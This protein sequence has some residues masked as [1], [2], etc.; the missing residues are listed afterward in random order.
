MT[1]Y[2]VFRISKR[3]R[4]RHDFLEAPLLVIPNSFRDLGV[5][6]I[7]GRVRDL[8]RETLDGSCQRPVK[9]GSLMGDPVQEHYGMTPPNVFLTMLL[10][11]I[12][13]PREE[14][15]IGTFG[16]QSAN[17]GQSGSAWPVSPSPRRVPL[18]GQKREC[19]EKEHVETVQSLQRPAVFRT[20]C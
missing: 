20:G 6:L 17:A 19:I 18:R 3:C 15:T 12:P 11:R 16:S 13:V 10:V 14:W 1:N 9:T 7:Q 8:G 5:D 2:R 4:S